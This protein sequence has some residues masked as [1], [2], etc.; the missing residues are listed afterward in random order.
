VKLPSSVLNLG[1]ERPVAFAGNGAGGRAHRFARAG[2]APGAAVLLAALLLVSGCGPRVPMPTRPAW[3]SLAVGSPLRSH[4]LSDKDAWLRHYVMFGEHPQAIGAFAEDSPLAPRDRLLRALQEGVALHEAGD[5]AR[6]NTVLEWAEVE[7]E[8]RYT[9]SLSREVASMLVSDRV[10]AYTPPAGELAMVPYYRMLN[11]LALGDRAG[12]LVEARKATALLERLQRKP[13]ERCNGDGVVQYIAGLVQRSAGEIN[14]AL[15][16]LRQAEQAFSACEGSPGTGGATV[17]VDLYR[18]ARAAGVM[19]VADSIASR[20]ALETEAGPPA[21]TGELLVIVE[22]GFV[23]HRT[24]DALHIPIPD[25][26]LKDLDGDDDDGVARLAG[27]VSQSLLYAQTGERGWRRRHR[28][29]RG[30]AW[31]DALDGAYILRLAWPTYRLEANRPRQV[32]VEVGELVAQPVEMGNVSVVMR[33]ELARERPE[34]LARLVL[35][36][37]TKYLISRE[38]EQKTEKKHGEAAGFLVGTLANLAGN[39]LEQA[40]TRSWTLLPDRISLLRVRLPAGRHPVR[41]EVVGDG[42]SARVRE[43]GEVTIEA[44]GLAVVRER[45]WSR[46]SEASWEDEFDRFELRLEPEEEPGPGVAPLA[47]D[48]TLA[49][50]S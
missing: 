12:A 29:Y 49:A 26:D 48:S 42:G 13:A 11:Y 32:R 6:S 28:A 3:E 8:L 23:A 24:Q 50:E 10:L 25:D 31:D 14:D 37:L 35:R 39:Q 27:A 5:Y 40:D 15:V 33:E 44:G 9:R 34:M 46:D 1:Y 22:H 45:V 30:S 7:A 20:Y 16:S 19:D 47:T 4:T 21:G 18:V 36:G 17:A 43:L 41:L 38:V 2:G